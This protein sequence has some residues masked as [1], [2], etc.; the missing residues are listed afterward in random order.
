MRVFKFPKCVKSIYCDIQPFLSSKDSD[1]MNKMHA[2]NIPIEGM[3]IWLGINMYTLGHKMQV[4][5][6]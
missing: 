2:A 3:M 6:F 1:V 5:K 4:L